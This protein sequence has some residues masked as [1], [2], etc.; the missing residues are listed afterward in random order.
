MLADG[1]H[2][3]LSP[4]YHL[5]VMDDCLTL[6]QL[7]HD[8]AARRSLRQVWQQACEYAC[9]MRHP[10][11]STVQFNDGATLLA[12]GHLLKGK[13]LG[14][15]SDLTS[16]RGGRH[17]SDSGII[18]WHGDPWSVF[19][20]V[21]QIGPD[22][23]P[24]HSHADTLNIECSFSGTRLFVDP[25][26]HSYDHDERRKYDRSTAA[27]NTVGIDDQDSSEVWHIFRVGRR[28]IPQDVSVEF[29]PQ[30]MKAHASHDGYRHL[31]GSPT[32]ARTVQV[33]EGWCASN[34]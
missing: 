9:W 32:H 34:S 25:G 29:L 4:F 22:V 11:G 1:S 28:A 7:L 31:S 5:E 24:G 33:E 26:C 23:Q 27:H 6:I 12:N 13:A 16:R 17:F 10:D 21:G 2:F 14:V 18:V 30:G 15:E 3:E 20:D 19:F 8:E